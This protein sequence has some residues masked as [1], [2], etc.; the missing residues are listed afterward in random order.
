MATE[1]EI[2]LEAELGTGS[3]GKSGSTQPLVLS[4]QSYR[5][6]RVVAFLLDWFIAAYALYLGLFVLDALIHALW[7]PSKIAANPLL[8]TIAYAWRQSEGV[9]TLGGVVLPK[10]LFFVLGSLP[11]PLL[12]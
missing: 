7:L 12:L 4:P 10:F 1:E 5:Q 9:T 8:D 3:L 2:R 6:R 11:I